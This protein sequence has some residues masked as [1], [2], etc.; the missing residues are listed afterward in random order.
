MS[1]SP[2]HF[3]ISAGESELAALRRRYKA[4]HDAYQ[5]CLQAL[6]QSEQQRERPSPELLEIEGRALNELNDA[7][8]RYRDALIGVAFPP[9]DAAR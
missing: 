7:R 6:E 8:R 2:R 1:E 3:A 5:S 9:D 4:A